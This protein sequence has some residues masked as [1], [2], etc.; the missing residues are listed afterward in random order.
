MPAPLLEVVGVARTFLQGERRIRVLEDI[1]CSL[2]AGQ[3]LT[4]TGRSGSGKS[5]LLNL[6]AGLDRPDAGRIRWHIADRY[7]DPATL[8]E[9]ARTGFRRRHLGFVFQFFNLVPTLTALENVAL[10]AEL[11]GFG[12]AMERARSRLQRLG[13]ED[14]MDAFPETLSGGEQQRVAI[15]RALVHEPAVVLADEPTGN[16]D[17]DSGDAVFAELLAVLAEERRALV[18]VT[19]DSELA[20]GGDHHLALGT[21]R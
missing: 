8:D 4:I 21:A 12:D 16:L 9:T 15:A 18:L 5:T 19:H 17:R 6:L 10:M 3:R 2:A 11:N 7:W 20:A 13:L 14:R 1:S